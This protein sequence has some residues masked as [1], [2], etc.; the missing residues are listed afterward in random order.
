MAAV[1]S[2]SQYVNTTVSDQIRARM[3]K[4]NFEWIF[5]EEGI[6]WSVYLRVYVKYTAH[7][8][9][10]NGFDCRGFDPYGA[11]I[12]TGGCQKTLVCKSAK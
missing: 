6:A 3:V 9:F 2:R 1:L 8:K 5:F 10:M 11:I 7:K 4:F 12:L